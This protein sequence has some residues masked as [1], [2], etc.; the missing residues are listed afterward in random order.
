MHVPVPVQPC[1]DPG[2]PSLFCVTSDPQRTLLQAAV[3]VR[4]A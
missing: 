1:C 4:G 3:F 2:E